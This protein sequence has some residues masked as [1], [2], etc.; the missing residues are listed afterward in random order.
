MARSILEDELGRKRTES[1]KTTNC[2]MKFPLHDAGGRVGGNRGGSYC[3]AQH[4]SRGVCPN[5]LSGFLNV[6]IVTFISTLTCDYK[7]ITCKYKR[8]FMQ[9]PAKTGVC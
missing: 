3:H 5:L 8:I 9:V 1:S 6:D 4:T 7:T 2:V